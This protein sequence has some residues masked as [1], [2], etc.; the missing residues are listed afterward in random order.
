M[1]RFERFVT[2]R[3]PVW[4]VG[5]LVVFGL[6]GTIAFS[7]I[8]VHTAQ[9]G[10][11]AG[12]AGD[13]I[14]AVSN[15]P[16]FLN[17]LVSAERYLKISNRRFE[18]RSGF[19]FA[20]PPGI[21]VDAGYL[22]LS[23]YDPDRARGVIELWDLNAQTE[24]HV[25]LP[26]IDEINRQATDFKS[27]TMDLARDKN[28]S[29]F[30]PRHPAIL[31]NGDIVIKSRTPLSRVDA[32][33]RIVWINDDYLFHHST[34][35]DTDGSLWVATVLNPPSI[36]R[37]N[38]EEFLDDA[39]T[40]VSAEGE[41]LMVRSVADI[42]LKQGMHNFVFGR[43]EYLANPIHLNDI[44]P[45]TADGP[46]WKKGDLFLSLR[47]PSMIA[48]YR[49][50]E[51]RIVWSKSGPWSHQHDV[52]VL[53]DHRIAVFNNNSYEAYPIP[54]IP[55]HS[56]VLVYDFDTQTVTSP[57]GDVLAEMALRSATEGLQQI[58]ASGEIMI[59][60]QNAG[61]L[62]A[63]DADQSLLWE[64]INRDEEGYQARLGWSRFLEPAAG[65]A[66]VAKLNTLTCQS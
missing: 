10:R 51:D 65:D 64:Y 3:V 45:V 28:Q 23:R 27:D 52:D 49:P 66:L 34:E 60:E 50:S 61:R 59:E 1:S 62:F 54:W 58:R 53:D 42:L 35:V 56:E 33:N 9:G 24:L 47:N 18:G 39:I 4:A 26:P 11:K 5:L 29:R 2:R 25:W 20:Y 6:I 7:N 15:I 22:L 48:L 19:T 16:K 32:C 46:Y 37:V 40:H 63:L 57:W 30:L 41:V 13:M 17:S 43:D 21:R 8:A 36:A 12:V 14:F 31:P 38:K 55:D 44:Q